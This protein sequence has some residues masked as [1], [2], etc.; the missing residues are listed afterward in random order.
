MN[1]QTAL[2]PASAPA[3]FAIKGFIGRDIDKRAEPHDVVDGLVSAIHPY[4]VVSFFTVDNEYA[5]HAA[6]LRATL[7]NFGIDHVLQPVEGSGRWE[8]NCAYKA[9]FIY[10]QWLLSDRPIVW[11]DADATV[12][13][14]PDLFSALD[15]DVALHKW[16]W[17]HAEQDRGWEFCSG[18]L[19]FGKTE[20]AGELLR[21]WML[22]CDAD[23]MTWDQVHLSSAWCDIASIK[24]LKTSWLPRSYLHIDGAPDA[25][26]AVIRHWQASR[27]ALAEGRKAAV[28]TLQITDAGAGDRAE[29]RLW[30]TPEEAFWIREG[31]DHIIPGTGF[32]F[33]EGFDVGATL[34]R[35]L[36]QRF[37]ILEIGCGVGR[38][39]SLFTPE[40][41]I[42]VDVNPNSLRQARAALP[43]HNFRI[44][45]HGYQYPAAPTVLIY[46]VLLHVADEA[47]VPLMVEATKGRE[48]VVIAELM[49]RRWRR[50]GNPPVFNRDPEVYIHLMQQLGFR[51]VDY[52]KHEYEHYNRAPWNVGRDSRIT[53]LAFDKVASDADAGLASNPAGVQ[54]GRRGMKRSGAMWIREEDAFMGRFFQATGDQFEIDHLNAAL[55]HCRGRRMALD[56]GAHYGSWSRYMARQFDRVLSFEPVRATYECCRLNVAEFDNVTLTHQAVGDRAGMVSVAP[57]KMYTHPGMETIVDFAGDTPMVRIDDLEL[58]AVDF[59]KIDVEGFERHV[60]EGAR[61]TLARCR[62]VIIFEENL[63][64]PLEHGV[65]NG[66]CAALLEGLGARLLEVKNKDFIF[67]WPEQD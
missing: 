15:A 3:D 2:P 17:N 20:L 66:E 61:E 39:A 25:E 28:E 33:P 23:P 26:T 10:E 40:G 60:L 38:I 12:E 21:Q 30:R 65:P 24:P 31:V 58:N 46:T 37:P 27:Q 47:L 13:A 32:Q 41:Y 8:L 29:N 43:D 55:R 14:L 11:L 7:E 4:R 9:R 36:G 64:G 16:T 45:D 19:Y 67:G 42:G 53:F 35:M 57:G 54:E 50:E 48:R 52:S 62:P 51:L 22:R 44:H 5:D 59:I 6:R 34:G 56:I 49:D 1:L 18:T 63:R